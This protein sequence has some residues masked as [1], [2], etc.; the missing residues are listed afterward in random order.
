M[1]QSD[2]K[3]IEKAQMGIGRKDRS[4]VYSILRETTNFWP[5]K[6]MISVNS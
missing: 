1:K 5:L 2:N 3:A 4:Y 6:Y